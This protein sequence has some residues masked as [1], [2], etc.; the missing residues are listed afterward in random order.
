MP[1]AN[2]TE[3][4]TATADVAPM[5]AMSGHMQELLPLD[6]GH[7]DDE[8]QET[9]WTNHYRCPRCGHVWQDTWTAQCDDDCGECG[10]RH[11]TPF[12]SDDGSCTTEQRDRALR[13]CEVRIPLS[14]G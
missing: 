11:I 7:D 5:S 10:T 14:A 6:G 1:E 3:T 2:A 12:F 9:T 13:E 8:D 4:T